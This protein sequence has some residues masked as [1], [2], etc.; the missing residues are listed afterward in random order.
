M[1][2]VWADRNQF[3]GHAVVFADVY[4]VLSE[5]HRLAFAIMV[6]NNAQSLFSRL[7]FVFFVILLKTILLFFGQH[8]YI[9]YVA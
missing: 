3:C 6:G 4:Q 8:Y 5:T 2:S 7:L 9:E 1:S